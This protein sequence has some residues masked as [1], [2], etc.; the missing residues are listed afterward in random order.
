MIFS[1]LDALIFLLAGLCGVLVATG[2]W[3]FRGE[4]WQLE[5]SSVDLWAFALVALVFTRLRWGGPLP[6]TGLWDLARRTLRR[7]LLPTIAPRATIVVLGAFALGAFLVHCFRHWSLSTHGFDVAFIHQA[8]H[9][10]WSGP[11]G[12]LKCDVC[13]GGS[14][15]GEHLSFSLLALAPLGAVLRGWSWRAEALFLLEAI[16][17]AASVGALLRWG[18][19]GRLRGAWLW[20][21]ALFLCSRGFRN[22]A[23]WD[24]REDHLAFAALSV[25]CIGV[26]RG[27]FALL[28]SGLVSALACKENVGFLAAF[29]AI[30][31]WLDPHCGFGPRRKLVAAG[32]AVM[33]IAWGVLEV[34][35]IL[36]AFS[37]TSGAGSEIATRLARFGSTPW[38][39]LVK[40]LS[41]PLEFGLALLQPISTGSGLKY[42]LWLALP[43]ICVA[44]KAPMWWPPAL[45]GAVMNLVSGAHTQRSMNFHYE[46]V[47]LPFLLAGTCSALARLWPAPP[48]TV[49]WLLLLALCASGRWPGLHLRIFAP[50]ADSYADARFLATVEGE[51]RVV[52][53]AMPTL[54]HLAHLPELRE[55]KIPGAP[56]PSDPDQA[57]SALWKENGK[58]ATGLP[59]RAA[60]LADGLVLDLRNDWLRFLS[61]AARERGWTETARSQGGRFVVYRRLTSPPGSHP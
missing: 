15:L 18:P 41:S 10:P 40:L 19:L 60:R 4:G 21:V 14:Y 37:Q 39:I 51:G 22:A 1:A 56:P 32:V 24:L 2:G 3:L 11:V 17:L 55:L 35:W 13:E 46:L 50:S 52:A 53:A 25:A 34:G 5:V 9:Y 7:A 42:L 48:R 27:S 47:F 59:D 44:W 33:S 58:D 54:A 38:E 20:G 45:V 16:L 49:A 6:A 30:P 29:L 36:P 43:F 26:F 57:W 8:V 61:D 31:I 12:A 23:F 28:G